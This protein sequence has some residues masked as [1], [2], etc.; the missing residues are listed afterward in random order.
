MGKRAIIIYEEGHRE[1]LND[2]LRDTQII[3]EKK[4][5]ATT[6]LCI[7]NKK[8]GHTYF[9]QL[10]KENPDYIISFAMAGFQWKTL[11][12]QISY[13][14][15]YAKQI[16]IL[17]GN[18]DIYETYLQKEYAINLFFFADH[19]RWTK[20]WDE[21][22][23][24]IPFMKKISTIYI[25]KKLSVDERQSNQKNLNQIIDQVIHIVED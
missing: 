12:S 14:L 22:Y 6:Q 20:K 2:L 19:E 23:A 1:V 7:S 25:G 13:N 9:E 21:R 4:Q 8:P 5:Y 17:I 16:H 11:A 15:L 24:G 10:K 3:M 18:Y